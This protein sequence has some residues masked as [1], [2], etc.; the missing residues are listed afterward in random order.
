MSFKEA[1]VTL[2]QALGTILPWNW[3]QLQLRLEFDEGSFSPS[4]TVQ[5]IFGP[6]VPFSTL[7]KPATFSQS[8]F[9]LRKASASD[10]AGPVFVM[11]LSWNR[12]SSPTITYRREDKEIASLSE[13]PRDV[14]GQMPLF[15]FKDKLPAKLLLEL[16]PREVIYALQTYVSANIEKKP[17][18]QQVLEI[19]AVHEWLTSVCRGGSD[20]Y[21]FQGPF[22]ES[23]AVAVMQSVRSGLRF[24]AEDELAVLFDESLRVY[25]PEVEA[26]RRICRDANL[27]PSSKPT[28]QNDD[29]VNRITRAV[30]N[31][32]LV[33]MDRVGKIIQNNVHTYATTQ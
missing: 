1:E 26:A 18:D 21:F 24:Q 4:G 9:G 17:I 15:M 10:P 7:S 13:V 2:V 25:A 20:S 19:V 16:K 23:Q 29:D 27:N 12:G 11:E 33:W 32:D 3:K 8:A 31:L 28:S 22:P 5:K 6:P 30:Q 14:H